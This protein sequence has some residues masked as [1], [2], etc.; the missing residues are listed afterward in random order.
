MRGL[1]ASRKACDGDRFVVISIENIQELGDRQ[2][3]DNAP[4]GRQEFEIPAASPE[5][6]KT[7]YDF[8]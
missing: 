5:S 6:R 2:Q 7:A 3:I 8:S 4:I 1:R